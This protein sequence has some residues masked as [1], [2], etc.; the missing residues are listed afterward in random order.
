MREILLNDLLS[1]SEQDLNRTKIKF[2]HYNGETD[3]LQE[4]LLNPEIVNNQWL[5]WR[6][7]RRN[8]ST[9]QIA[10]CLVRMTGD[11]WL[12]TT[13]KEVTSELGI[14]K[15]I[16]YAGVEKD[17]YKKYFGRVVVKYKKTDKVGC[18]NYHTVG[19]ELIVQQILPNVYNG[20]EFPGYDNVVLSYK[21]LDIINRMGKRDWIAALESQKAVYLITDIK[22]GKLYVGS[23]TAKYGMLLSRW[24]NYLKDGHGGNKLLKELVNEKG[25]NYV[26]ENFQ[27]SILENYNSIVDDSVIVMRESHWKNI[28]HSKSVGYN[29]N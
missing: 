22:T 14:Q 15:G 16:N 18:R 29:S 17:E 10:I 1:L 28:L 27:Y 19:K 3:P 4:F 7:N 13:I 20:E 12:L 9:G 26:K 24:R 5:F 11:T 8:F 2:N 6:K 23:A 21:Q 25:F